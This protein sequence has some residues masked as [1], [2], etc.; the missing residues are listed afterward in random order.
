[1][2]PVTKLNVLTDWALRVSSTRAPARQLRSM[3]VPSTCT[4]KPNVCPPLAAQVK[5]PTVV[6]GRLHFLSLKISD[7]ARAA[8]SALSIKFEHG[9]DNLS[10][11]LNSH[12][13][14]PVPRPS[15][16]PEDSIWTGMKPSALGNVGRGLSNQLAEVGKLF[17]S[18]LCRRARHADGCINIAG[19]VENWRS[20]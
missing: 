12:Y 7:H 9:L 15:H 20:G 18:D 16:C 17:P 1:M 13:A 6:P 10:N 4:S 11:W 3:A 14:R 2:A 19:V 8:E 5:L